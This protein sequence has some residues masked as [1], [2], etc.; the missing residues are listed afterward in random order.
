MKFL[1][2]VFLITLI[3]ISAIQ[4]RV[5]EDGVEHYSYQ[6]PTEE[7]LSCYA[8]GYLYGRAAMRNMYGLYTNPECDNLVIPERC[9][10]KIE[11]KTGMDDGVKSI[12]IFI[13][14]LKR[15]R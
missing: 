2:V 13:N 12:V 5:G 9:Q 3:H 8:S 7:G 11:T 1:F 4:V 10:G 15:G 14:S 6:A